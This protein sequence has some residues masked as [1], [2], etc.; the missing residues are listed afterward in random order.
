MGA[1]WGPDLNDALARINLDK[2]QSPTW[3]RGGG[4]V[5]LTRCQWMGTGA[6]SQSPT[7]GRGGGRQWL[8][9][10]SLVQSER[11]LNPLRGGGVGAGSSASTRASTLVG[12]QSPTWGRGGGRL[13]C[14]EVERCRLRESQSPT[15]GRGGGRLT[16]QIQAIDENGKSQSPTW[17][18]GGGRLLVMVLALRTR[19]SLNP[20]R[21]G[22]V[23][24][25][26]APQQG[27][28]LNPLRGGGVGAGPSI[29]DESGVLFS[30]LSQSPTW[31][32][33]GGRPRCAHRSDDAVPGV[34]IPY[35]G[36]GWGPEAVDRV[37]LPAGLLSQ[38]PTW[39]RGGGRTR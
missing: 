19:R 15:W 7:W 23:G 36:A 30:R 13:G 29:I 27:R 22:G 17:G 32:R 14:S 38:S 4:R 12:S 16:A 34:S 20:L 2:S 1:G 9:S 39:G 6:P 25:G 11:C 35:V 24:A 28:G 10:A 21:G 8:I 18:R 3:G 5:K 31:G 37:A 33:G 26:Q